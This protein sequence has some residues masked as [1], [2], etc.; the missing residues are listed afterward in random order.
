MEGHNVIDRAVD[1]IADKLLELEIFEN[2][3]EVKGN[4]IAANRGQEKESEKC[5]STEEIAEL[6][7][8]ALRYISENYD[9]TEEHRTLV[10][11][12]EKQ[13]ILIS[14]DNLHEDNSNHAESEKKETSVITEVGSDSKISTSSDDSEKKESASSVED[15][16]KQENLMHPEDSAFKEH[17]KIPSEALLEKI[18]QQA[19]FY[20]SDFNILKN[21]FLLKHVRRNKEGYV[22][23]KLVA[24]FRKIKSMTKDWRVVAYSLESSKL[25]EL[26][27]EKTKIRRIEPIP[28]LEETNLGKTVI[29]FNLP[30]QNPN[31]EELKEMFSKFGNIIHA[32]IMTTKSENYNTYYK[33]CRYH[34]QEIASP[35]FGSVEFERFEDALSAIKDE[36]SHLPKE[37]KMKVVPL[38]PQVYRT[39]ARSSRN[40][41]YIHFP[42]RGSGRFKSRHDFQGHQ[43]SNMIPFDDGRYGRPAMSEKH[44]RRF[45]RG[46]NPPKIIHSSRSASEIPEKMSR[47]AYIAKNEDARSGSYARSRQLKMNNSMNINK[48]FMHRQPRYPDGTFGFRETYFDGR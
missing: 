31:S 33:R 6:T 28:K 42:R 12:G 20:F 43:M 34:N 9:D 3:N 18:V 35:V 21:N 24:S 45:Y 37:N 39:K 47:D 10:E 13:D 44:Y 48:Q 11:K 30:F 1:C 27:A 32:E 38:M 19:E 22:S 2:N 17:F 16:N 8:K 26:N 36:E 14:T 15:E 7:S 41:Q 40:N 5:S 23:L 4:I 46:Y 29:V 25:L